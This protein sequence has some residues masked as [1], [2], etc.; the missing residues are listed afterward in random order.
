ME[1]TV[2]EGS[3]MDDGYYDITDF[4]FTAFCLL[5]TVEPCFESASVVTFSKEQI[6]AEFDQMLSDFRN[7]MNDVQAAFSRSHNNEAGSTEG[8]EDMEEKDY[9]L[10]AAPETGSVEGV[11][12]NSVI[13]ENPAEKFEKE[14]SEERA[15]H[16]KDVKELEDLKEK[17]SKLLEE[18]EELRKFKADVEKE[19]ADSE[20]A[21]VFAKFEDLEGNESFAALKEEAENYSL[22]VLEEKCYAIRGRVSEP[23]R[24]MTFSRKNT[25]LPAGPEVKPEVSPYG[26]LFEKYGH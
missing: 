26:G 22:D 8:G 14:L 19:K 21:D 16:E 15:Q 11:V 25:K 4:E 10:E 12:V 9:T 7:S 1:I 2:K 13:E 20:R 18:T 17:Y 24:K 6:Q 5:G 3:T 23:D